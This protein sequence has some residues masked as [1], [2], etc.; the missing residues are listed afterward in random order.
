MGTVWLLWRTAPKRT[1]EKAAVKSYKGFALAVLNK[2]RLSVR[3]AWA[4]RFMAVM[5]LAK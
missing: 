4:M 1:V 3:R 2:R 5:H